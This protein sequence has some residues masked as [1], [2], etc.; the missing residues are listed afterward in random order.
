MNWIIRDLRKSNNKFTVVFQSQ[1]CDDE[2]CSTDVCT[3]RPSTDR[4]TGTRLVYYTHTVKQWHHCYG[5]SCSFG[6]LAE[7]VIQQKHFTHAWPYF[8]HRLYPNPW[9]QQ[10]RWWP[11]VRRPSVSSCQPHI[12]HRSSPTSPTYRRALCSPPP[13]ALGTWATLCYQL[14]MLRRFVCQRWSR[15]YDFV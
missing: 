9:R 8:V 3:H 10:P 15:A 7:S 6:L 4:Q 5:R 12:C 1:A 14:H 13:T 11:P 2:C